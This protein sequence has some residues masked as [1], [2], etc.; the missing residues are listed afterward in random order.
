MSSVKKYLP[1]LLL[2]IP[3]AM[4]LLRNRDSRL[5][6]GELRLLS[7][8]HAVTVMALSN[9]LVE[10]ADSKPLPNPPGDKCEN[11]YG[12]GRSG[13]GISVCGVCG[14]TGKRSDG[15]S[16]PQGS[17]K[18]KCDNPK[19]DCDDCDCDDCDCGVVKR[20]YLHTMPGCPPCKRWKDVELPKAE[21]AGWEVEIV[22]YGGKYNSYPQFRVYQDV[23]KQGGWVK[24]FQTFEQL[25]QVGK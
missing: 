4:F 25:R 9:D 16:L 22:Q 5:D 11:C 21:A 20:I 23:T 1:L 3:V 15:G 8:A 19:C 12:T 2:L 14:G 6:A 24:G 17:A 18:V 7:K 10:V 13:D